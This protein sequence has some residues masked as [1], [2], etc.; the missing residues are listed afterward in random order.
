MDQLSPVQRMC[1]FVPLIC[2]MKYDKTNLHEK[3][4][5]KLVQFP[6]NIPNGAKRVRRPRIGKTDF[7]AIIDNDKTNLK[8]TRLFHDVRLR[9]RRALI[10]KKNT[11]QTKP[12]Q[13]I[14]KA[15]KALKMKNAVIITRTKKLF[16]SS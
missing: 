9:Q 10:N 3:W 15:S 4:S 6:E 7:K 5:S 14:L 12:R 2:L 16:K 13:A 8:N 1:K 11:I